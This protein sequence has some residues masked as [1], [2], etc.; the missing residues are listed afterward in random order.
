MSGG[1]A[2]APFIGKGEKACPRL[3][4]ECLPVGP[5]LCLLFG[6][7]MARVEGTVWASDL[8]RRVQVP[9]GWAVLSLQAVLW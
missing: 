7:L 5:G 4:A 6:F 9:L 1:A 2:G 8:D 3:R